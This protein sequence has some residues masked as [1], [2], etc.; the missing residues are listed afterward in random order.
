MKTLRFARRFGLA[1]M[2]LLL[3]L[4]A[5]PA[6]A[7]QEG[8]F[9]FNNNGTIAVLTGY[10]GPGGAV[11]IPDRL[12]NLPVASIGTSAFSGRADLASVTIPNSVTSTRTAAF[13]NCTGLTSVYFEGKLPDID[14]S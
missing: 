11:V 12:G 4:F 10:V 5:T 6:R 8:D 2:L 14:S 13:I 9:I 3:A 7:A 1:P